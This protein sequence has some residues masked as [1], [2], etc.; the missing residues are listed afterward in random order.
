MQVY[1]KVYRTGYYV[2]TTQ[3]VTVS[4]EIF[5]MV[6]F[7]VEFLPPLV[8]F[9]SP[10]MDFLSPVVVVRFDTFVLEVAATNIIC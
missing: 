2:W 3:C 8:D 9:L 4:N 6:N 10:V 5:P 1:L 7:V